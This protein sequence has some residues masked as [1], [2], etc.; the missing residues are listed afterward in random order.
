ERDR[1]PLPGT[2]GS[3]DVDGDGRADVC[4]RSPTGFACTLGA[5]ATSTFASTVAGPGLS[6]GSGWAD[7]SNALSMAMGDIDGDGRDDLC[8]RA[9]A[10]VR[11]W[12]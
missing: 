7:L 2:L 6:D 1:P 9:N 12:R 11:C 8:A 4:M 5:S 3:S 10:G